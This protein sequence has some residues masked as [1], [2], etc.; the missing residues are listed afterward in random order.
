MQAEGE[1][2]AAEQELRFRRMVR[3]ELPFLVRV[4]AR[5]RLEVVVLV[6]VEEDVAV[7]QVLHARHRYLF[8]VLARGVQRQ[9]RGPQ[10]RDVQIG[11]HDVD[12]SK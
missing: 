1:I 2:E 10:F 8:R 3:Q 5:D 6:E 11:A 9:R 4:Q 12:E 7:V